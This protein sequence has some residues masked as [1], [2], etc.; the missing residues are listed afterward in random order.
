LLPLCF[1]IGLRWAALV[2]GIGLLVL[3]LGVLTL[4]YSARVPIALIYLFAAFLFVDAYKGCGDRAW[5]IVVY[6][7]LCG[8]LLFVCP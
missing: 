5:V 8:P 6:F 3:I 2:F 7:I 1:I 4:G